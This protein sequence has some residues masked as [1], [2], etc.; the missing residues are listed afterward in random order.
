VS[1][2]KS[3]EDVDIWQKAHEFVLGVY[4]LTDE[5]PKHELFCLTSQLRR[6]A[7]SIPANF[8][9]GFRKQSKR[10]K[11][12]FYNIAIGSL[13]ECRYYLRLA[14]DLGYADTADLR[15]HLETISRMLTRYSAAIRADF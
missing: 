15:N 5:F 3:F 14:K 7:I 8:A 2:A 11:V 12:R 9:E 10:D 6:A 4:R 13:E 1:A